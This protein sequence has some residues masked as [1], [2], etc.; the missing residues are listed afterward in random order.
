MT[1][2]PGQQP[3]EA[4]PPPAELLDQAAT[5]LTRR[6]HLSPVPTAGGHDG[7]HD[8][9]EQGPSREARTSARETDPATGT[10]SGTGGHTGGH[11]VG[12][13]VPTTAGDSD[14]GPGLL[15]TAAA[16]VHPPEV[17]A[18]LQDGIRA[19]WAYAQRGG[20]IGQHAPG[21]PLWRG[22]A[23]SYQVA[24]VPLQALLRTAEWLLRR[25]SRLALAVAGVL[26]TQQATITHPAYGLLAWLTG[27]A[28]ALLTP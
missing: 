8:S 14:T 23:L 12:T 25:P 5:P 21:Y 11:S 28:Q 15:R 20:W 24:T 17:I 1:A 26:L 22:L 16:R 18:E 13:P 9:D 4:G 7:G 19:R 3:A 10:D 27:L 6:A 2:Q